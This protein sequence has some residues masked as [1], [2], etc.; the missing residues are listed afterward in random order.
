MGLFKVMRNYK[1]ISLIHR[2]FE[3]MGIV[4]QVLNSV[5]FGLT[6]SSDHACAE[7]VVKGFKSM[8]LQGCSY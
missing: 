4:H 2:A 1:L 8:P 6:L 7:A 3:Y 5:L